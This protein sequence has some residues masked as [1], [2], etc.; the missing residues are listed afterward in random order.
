MDI[1]IVVI[2]LLTCASLVLL[3]AVPVIKRRR[4]KLSDSVEVEMG[5]SY[6]QLIKEQVEAR[7]MCRNMDWRD[8]KQ[9]S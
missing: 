2:S 9:G 6:Y 1:L 5:P 8:L 3:V 4:W 7:S